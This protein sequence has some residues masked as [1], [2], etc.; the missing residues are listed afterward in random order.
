MN[1]RRAR[2]RGD[3][4]ERKAVSFELKLLYDGVSR[5][6]R[7]APARAVRKMGY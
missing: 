2:R 3:R 6:V 7:G 4:D 1:E 5:L